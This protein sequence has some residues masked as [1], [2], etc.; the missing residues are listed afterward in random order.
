MDDFRAV[1]Q[2]VRRMDAPP[3]LT[4]QERF[5]S[6]L[7]V[8]GMLVARPVTSP[9]AHARILSIDAT[10]ALE[11]PGVARVLTADDLTIARDTSGAPVKAPIAAGEVVYAGQFVALVLAETDAAAQDGVAMVEVQY[12]PLPVITTLDEALDPSSPHIRET[13]Q[14]ANDEEAAMHNA[15]AAV[16]AEEN[17]QFVAPNVSNSVRFVRGDVEAGFTAA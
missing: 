11:V 3:K 10:R 15:D 17:D 1:G 14:Q 9:Y 13:R 6:D 7:Q 4:G 5:T 2:R 12:E 16:Q 8:P